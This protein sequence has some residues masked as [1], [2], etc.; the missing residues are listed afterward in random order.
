[1]NWFDEKFWFFF[2]Q[3]WMLS[4]TG[5]IR[6]DEAC[7]DFAGTDVILYPCH[8][9]KG[10]QF[11]MYDHQVWNFFREINFTKKYTYIK[12]L[13]LIYNFHSNLFFQTHTLKHGSSRKCLALST[14]KD[15]LLMESCDA[16]EP[17]QR[18]KFGTFN[19]SNTAKPWCNFDWE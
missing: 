7:L 3:Y 19:P 13:I 8:G 2:F 12:I 4:K 6:R 14:N 9:S 1:M 16:A 17:R 18:W 11:W 10:N 15:R 5:E